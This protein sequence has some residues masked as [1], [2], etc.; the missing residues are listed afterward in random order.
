MTG[1][2]GFASFFP[3]VIATALGASG[4]AFAGAT[5]LPG[6]VC[7]A[8]VADLVSVLFADATGFTGA[9]IFT[10]ALTTGFFASCFNRVGAAFLI[11]SGFFASGFLA[12]GLGDFFV[13]F[14]FEGFKAF[15]AGAFAFG[16]GF[17]KAGLGFPA[18]FFFGADFFFAIY[19]AVHRVRGKGKQI[20][21]L[22]KS[23]AGLGFGRV[24][25]FA[26]RKENGAVAQLVRARDS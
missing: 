17:F 8:T 11:G 2:F 13:A 19:D 24:P 7:L 12:E 9:R 3:L 20:P 16:D 4:D 10:G 15:F 14:G 5:V 18:L 26:A 22:C 23:T 6:V 25:I 21:Y 1:S